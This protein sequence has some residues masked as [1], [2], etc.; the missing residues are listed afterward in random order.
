[1]VMIYKQMKNEKWKREVIKMTIEEYQKEADKMINSTTFGLF[2]KLNKFM[3]DYQLLIEEVETEYDYES[4]LQIRNLYNDKI[5]TL[6][7][8]TTTLLKLLGIQ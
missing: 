5:K 2:A 1:M 3:G 6:E 8:V 7:E 4:S